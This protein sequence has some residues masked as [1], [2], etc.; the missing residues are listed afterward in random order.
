MTAHNT[1]AIR[2]E[3]TGSTNSGKTL[4]ATKIAQVLHDEFSKPPTEGKERHHIEVDV[5]NLDGDVGYK[6]AQ[7]QQNQFSLDKVSA[8]HVS[9]VDRNLP[10]VDPEVDQL[11]HFHEARFV[12]NPEGRRDVVKALL[13]EPR[14]IDRMADLFE[15]L[16]VQARIVHVKTITSTNYHLRVHANTD[17]VESTSAVFSDHVFDY[18][19]EYLR[20]EFYRADN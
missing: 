15:E 10:Y 20:T 9:I 14:A 3:I 17:G 19:G 18:Q 1:P 6:L 12:M 11:P 16:G 2:I 13:V 4:I 8:L 5:Y 7:M